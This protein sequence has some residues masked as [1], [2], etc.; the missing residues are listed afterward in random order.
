LGAKVELEHGRVTVEGTP[1][2]GARLRFGI[3]TVTGTANV[4]MAA[5]FAEGRTL[6]ENAACEPEVVE[7]VR[8]L[9]Q[10]GAR[11]EG[12]GT[13]VITVEGVERLRPFDWEVIPDRIETGTFLAAARMNPGE[14]LIE[15]C[16]PGDLQSVIERLRATGLRVEENGNSLWA[17]GE[18][19][20]RSVDVKT[21]PYPG[22]PTDMQAQ[23]M[24]VLSMGEGIGVVT[25]TV[26][27]N[28]FTHVSELRRMGAHIQ[29][30]GRTA[31]VK[32]GPSLSGAPVMATDLRASACLVLAGLAAKGATTISRVYHLDR[33]YEAIELKLRGLGASITRV[34]V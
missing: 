14:I 7:L 30:E 3:S 12:G 8:V 15:R 16:R 9:Q 33:G 2:K 19:P 17:K 26:F 22:F 21:E 24:A 27:E 4:L 10:M 11:I 31:I 32:G 13:E 23:M 20:I 29:V 28:R 5:I 25:E 6:L 34:R 18:G 1:L